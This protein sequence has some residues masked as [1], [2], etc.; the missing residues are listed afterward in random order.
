MKKTIVF[1]L[2]SVLCLGLIACGAATEET[3][4]PVS[5]QKPSQPVTTEAPTQSTQPA[6]T[7]TPTETATSELVGGDWRTW[8]SYT[9]DIEIC[10][11]LTVCLSR[12]DDD[13]GYGVFDCSNG[14]RI[15]SLL[16]P[17]GVTGFFDQGP[18]SADFDGDGNVD[19]GIATEQRAVWFS[20]DAAM[21]GSWPEDLG[22]FREL[23][24]PNADPNDTASYPFEEPEI[25]ASELDWEIYE[26]I[27]PKVAA[28]EDFYYDAETYGYEYMDAMLHA[29]GIIKT[30]HPET[31]NYF[32]LEEV[33]DG[34][35]FKGMRSSY[36]CRWQDEP[37]DDKA[38]I[39]AGMEAFEEK[40]V[41]ILAGLNDN[42][43]AYDKYL[44]FA[45]VISE[46][47]SYDYDDESNCSEAPW[48]GIMGGKFICEGYS[49]A[50]EYLCRRANLYCKI[51]S[52]S[53]R[54]VSH[55]WNLVKVASGTYH[56]DVTWADEQGEPGGIEWMRYFM[57]TQDVIEEDHVINDGT[58]ATGT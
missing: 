53:S 56:V 25:D 50:M 57:L 1:L 58:V 36:T 54:S 13:T 17:E 6:T 52:G 44:Y 40:T 2:V 18:F 21:M 19:I 38:V 39:R 34:D 45:K 41:E 29:F 14:E 43:S 55:A 42:M 8:R 33:F 12:L 9:P 37:S 31:R 27:Y 49:E 10:D 20:F 5:T 16:I 32:M 48:A 28:L 30:L 3:V 47:A 22:A 15:G 24:L 35:D 7:E 51:V 11:D 23:E 4:P 26:E 46:N